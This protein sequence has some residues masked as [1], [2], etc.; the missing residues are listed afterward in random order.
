MSAEPYASTDVDWLLAINWPT[1]SAE[2]NGRPTGVMALALAAVIAL[3]GRWSAIAAWA[4]AG[5]FLVGAVVFSIPFA[6]EV[7]E[8]G[9]RETIRFS[10][11]DAVWFGPFLNYVT[12]AALLVTSAAFAREVRGD[13]P[14]GADHLINPAG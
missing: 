5:L 9:C 14:L 7:V 8:V 2:L 12:G 6:I 1:I 4:G 3:R 13:A 11:W 10:L